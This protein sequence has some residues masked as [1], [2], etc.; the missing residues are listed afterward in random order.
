MAVRLTITENCPRCGKKQAWQEPD[1]TVRESHNC[2]SL[3]PGPP[4]PPRRFRPGE[5][6]FVPAPTEAT[7]EK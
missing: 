1:G 5:V 3:P 2:T 7:P 4:A 6:V